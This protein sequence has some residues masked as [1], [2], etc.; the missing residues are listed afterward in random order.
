V[1]HAPYCRLYLQLAESER[2]PVWTTFARDH[3]CSRW[4]CHGPLH[5]MSSASER[6]RP[7]PD[8]PNGAS[9]RGWCCRAL[10]PLL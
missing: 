5:G 10:C 1:R 3:P 6:G 2:A 9:C 4:V 7:H 8:R